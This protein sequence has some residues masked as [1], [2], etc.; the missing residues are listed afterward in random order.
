MYDSTRRYTNQAM[1]TMVS[2]GS[3][4]LTATA[5]GGTKIAARMYPMLST[6][7]DGRSPRP[8]ERGVAPP[9]PGPARKG[10]N[11]LPVPP[12]PPVVAALRDTPGSVV[13]SREAVGAVVASRELSMALVEDK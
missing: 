13:N 9:H 10:P 12:V 11:G 7:G 6:A 1:L 8:R 4:V 3:P 5:R 2:Q